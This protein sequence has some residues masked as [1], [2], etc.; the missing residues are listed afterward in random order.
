MHALRR[1]LP[2]LVGPQRAAYE[3][4]RDALV[5]SW[6]QTLAVLAFTLNPAFL[7]LD[8]FIMPAELMGRFAIYR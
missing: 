5:H 7:I 4:Y 1:A 2:P 3:D 8:A 6:S